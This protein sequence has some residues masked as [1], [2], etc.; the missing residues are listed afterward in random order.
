V[1]L[2]EELIRMHGMEPYKDIDIKFTGM[3]PGEKLFEELLTAEE[4]TIATKYEKVFIARTKENYEMNDIET[5]LEEIH[6]ALNNDGLTVD[7][8]IRTILR[9]YVQHYNKER[10]T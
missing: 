4:G 9:K 8:E 10:T 7:T 6:K 2:A 1:K 5:I 3:R